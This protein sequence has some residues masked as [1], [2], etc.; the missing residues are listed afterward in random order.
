VVVVAIVPVTTAV[1]LVI[2]RLTAQSLASRAAVVE[3][4]EEEEE[5]IILATIAGRLG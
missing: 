4:E 5:E 1:S 3:E 2:T